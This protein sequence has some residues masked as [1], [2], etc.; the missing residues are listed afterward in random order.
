MT[1]KNLN[2]DFMGKVIED[3]AWKEV[4][5]DLPWSEQL[6]DKYKDKVNWEKVSGNSEVL[7]TTSMLEKYKALID[8]NELSESSS[9]SLF[10]PE[11]LEKYKAYWNWPNLSSNRYIKFNRELVSKFA[12]KWDWEQLISNWELNELFGSD[13]LK[14]F[15]QYIPASAL[16]SSSLWDQLVEEKKKELVNEIRT[17]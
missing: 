16:Q 4:S 12:D 15:S 11:M 14:E 7:W 10:S 8:W 6:L 9:W 17:S 13:F 3:L 5:G 1:T 2:D